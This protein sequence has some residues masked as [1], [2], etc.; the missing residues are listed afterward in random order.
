MKNLFWDSLFPSASPKMVM[1][2]QSA[3]DLPEAVNTW[4]KLLTEYRIVTKMH[5]KL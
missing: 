4:L 2:L 5:F 1:T 3:L